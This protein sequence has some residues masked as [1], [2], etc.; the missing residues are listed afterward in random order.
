M[1]AIDTLQ[2]YERL[3]KAKASDALSKE[4]AEII[5]NIVDEQLSTKADLKNTEL[6][7]KNDLKNTELTLKNELKSTEAKLEAKLKNTEAKLEAKLK[8]IE[9]ALK[10]TEVKLQAEIQTAVHGSKTEIIKWI[11]GW[12][13]GLLMAQT[14]FLLTYLK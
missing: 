7:M 12:V 2:I 1:H 14:G 5:G 4:M 10:N 9:L 6:A 13:T 11:I 8:N 3:K